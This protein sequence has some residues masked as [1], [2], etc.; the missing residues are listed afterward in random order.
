MKCIAIMQ[1]YLFPY[2]GYF[3]LI[4]SVDQFVLL[5]DVNYI[6][7][8]WVNRNAIVVNQHLQGFTVP[9]EKVSQNKLIKDLELMEDGKWKSKLLK[10]I[11]FSYK[12]AREF[13]QVYP[14]ME[15]IIHHEENN[16][17]CF[18][19]NS[20]EAITTYLEIDT[21]L[22]MNSHRENHD[23]WKGQQRIIQICKRE[24]AG[25]Y[26]NLRGGWELYH[27]SLFDEHGLKLSF[28]DVRF[29]P[30]PQPYPQFI[31]SLSIID[32]LM[33]NSKSEVKALLQACDIKDA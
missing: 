28:L 16:L 13:S 7:R 18:I 31:P 19:Y 22:V 15:D 9:V 8:G 17:A 14:L 23:H 20:I 12:K 26:L 6:K 33:H 2:I 3:Q 10:T 1:P 24:K 32:V 21:P 11:A 29:Q 4:A 5:D 25:Q 30:Y 27:K